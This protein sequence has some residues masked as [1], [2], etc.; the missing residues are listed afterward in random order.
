MK[1]RST[2]IKGV[3]EIDIIPSI[4]KRGLFARTYDEEM[5]ASA[6]LHRA[7]PQCN[8]SWNTFRGT[9]RGMHYQGAP[10]EDPKLVRCTRGRVF[11]VVVDLRRGS[12]TFREWLSV[13]LSADERNA[14]YIPAGCAHGFLTLEDSSEVLYQMGVEYVSD[15]GRGVRWD[16]PTFGIVWPFVPSVISDRDANFEDYVS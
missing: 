9:L 8:T 2:R 14:I 13:E 7:W 4:D 12:S 11:D 16:D 1:I 15:L 10:Y 6:N 5:F 3:F